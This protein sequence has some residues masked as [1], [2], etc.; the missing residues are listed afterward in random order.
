MNNVDPIVL[1]TLASV[2]HLVT[3][4]YVAVTAFL[5]KYGYAAIVVLMV[6]E[7]ASLPIP[8]EVVLPLIGKY[9]ASGLLNPYLAFA[10]TMIGTAIGISVDYAIAYYFGKD[11]VYKHLHAFHVKKETV[12]AF[13]AWFDSNG[14][15]AVFV[16]R[17]L[18]IVRGLISLP[19]GFARMPLKKFF[20][21]SLVASAIWNAALMYFGYALL[22]TNNV[23]ILF[24]AVAVLAI[25]LYAIYYLA[26]GRIRKASHKKPAGT[27]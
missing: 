23:D 25:V 13:D 20:L 21:Y 5:T 11:V 22:S 27:A 4:T 12:D 2:L 1:I 16:S 18:P 7:S 9:V 8:S 19:A 26:V 15:F 10:C 17:L 24:A 14:A 3:G 6:L